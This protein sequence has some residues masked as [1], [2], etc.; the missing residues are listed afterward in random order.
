MR[1]DV[2][3]PGPPL[4]DLVDDLW[5]LS[6]VPAHARERIVPSGTQGGPDPPGLS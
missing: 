6:D 2:H 5:A 1:Y 3:V 4:F